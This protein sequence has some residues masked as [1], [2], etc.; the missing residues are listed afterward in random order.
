MKFKI[1][2]CQPAVTQNRDE[3][4]K[5]AFKSVAAAAD[6]GAKAVLLPEI[7]T[8]PYTRRAIRENP[9]FPEGGLVEEMAAL[10]EKKGIYLFAGT[11]PEAEGEK[12]Y[13]TCFVYDPRGNI[14]GK[15]R[16]THLFDVDLGNLRFTESQLFESGG[17]PLILDTELGRIGVAVCF[18]IRFSEYM[19]AL[20]LKGVE[21]LM[22]PSA[23]AIDTG[24]SHW[25]ILTRM[26]AI[27]SQAY[28]AGAL[29]ARN[30]EL[31]YK[32]YGHSIIS[33]PWGLVIGELDE[34]EGVLVREI[35]TGN[36]G[37]IRE[38][39]PLLKGRRPELYI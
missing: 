24:E 1:G 10:A 9:E 21:L 20:G 3:N 37:R 25:R 30:N 14:I 32:S 23:F 12:R 11:I 26:R 15:Y 29:S 36:V 4:I 19:V 31:S 22:V 28:L 13:N 16:K 39:F 34:K 5:N 17:S 33:D 18:D 35:D 38:G 7:F 6:M 27:D 2:V 8:V